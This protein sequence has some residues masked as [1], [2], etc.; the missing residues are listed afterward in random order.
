MSKVEMIP[1][2]SCWE[3]IGAKDRDG[4]GRFGLLSTP[5]S[6]EAHRVSW[7]LHNGEIPEGLCVC[8]R[9]DNT[10]CV[11]PK[12]LFLGTIAENNKDKIMKGRDWNPGKNI[13]AKI[14]HCPKGHEYNKENTSFRNKI[15]RVC[16]TCKNLNSKKYYYRNKNADF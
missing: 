7:F 13:Q 12:H 11:N 1:E 4:Y 2:H 16:R 9:C 3:W 15:W 5:S 8:H 6:I 10:S 14:T